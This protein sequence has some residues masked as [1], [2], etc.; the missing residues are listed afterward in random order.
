MLKSPEVGTFKGRPFKDTL[1]PIELVQTG[2]LRFK[3]DSFATPCNKIGSIRLFLQCNMLHQVVQKFYHF[4]RRKSECH[5]HVRI[6]RHNRINFLRYWKTSRFPI[7]W[8][9]YILGDIKSWSCTIFLKIYGISQFW[10]GFNSCGQKDSIT[11]ITS[12]LICL[13]TRKM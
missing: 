9:W 4:G 11:T 5:T 3:V 1:A 7:K 6:P 10:E 2:I 13:E 12:K 8:A